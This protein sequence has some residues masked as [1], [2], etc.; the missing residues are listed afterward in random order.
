M[1]HR[2]TQLAQAIRQSLKH[3]LGR[4]GAAEP[5]AR[6]DADPIPKTAPAPLPWRRAVRPLLL[7]SGVLALGWALWAHPP[8]QHVARGEVLVRSNALTGGVSQFQDGAVLVIP[9]IEEC[10]MM[11]SSFD[12]LLKVRTSDIAGYRRFLGE[13]ISALPHV[14]STSTYV[15]MEAVKEAG[16]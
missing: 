10:H 11:A 16:L 6:A 3:A 2:L 4:R 14:A 1:L 9:E 12:Y 5:G 7:G 15:A 13:R 8:L